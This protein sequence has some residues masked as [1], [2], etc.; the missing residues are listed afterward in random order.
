MVKIN[1]RVKINAPHKGK[2]RI[3]NES[4]VQDCICCA[5]SLTFTH[6]GTLSHVDTISSHY[7]FTSGFGKHTWNH[8]DLLWWNWIFLGTHSELDPRL[9]RILWPWWFWSQDMVHWFWPS[10][11]RCCRFSF[12]AAKCPT[13]IWANY[14]N[15]LTWNK[16]IWGW[17]PLLAMISSE[18]EQWGRDEIYPDL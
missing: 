8:K 6:L 7:C 14:S 12:L 4:N 15:S 3:S 1:V 5:L 9:I 11:P 10:Q 18:G 2:R 13:S 16:A 17:F